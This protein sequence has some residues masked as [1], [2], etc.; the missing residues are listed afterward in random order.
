M[1]R[2]ISVICAQCTMV[3]AF[4]MITT[5]HPVQGLPS[6]VEPSGGVMGPFLRQSFCL[7]PDSV[8][9]LSVTVEA[10][11]TYQ[12]QFRST[13]PTGPALW[14]RAQN[15]ATARGRG[16]ENEQR[17]KPNN[18]TPETQNKTLNSEANF[19]FRLGQPLTLDYNL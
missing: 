13:E 15:R 16:E 17:N 6:K 9:Y 3:K 14:T 12:C 2:L 7:L 18:F 4:I 1:I 11:M 10:S 19:N 5:H 8:P